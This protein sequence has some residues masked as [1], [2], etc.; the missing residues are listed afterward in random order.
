MTTTKSHYEVLEIPPTAPAGDIKRAFRQQIALYHPDKVQHLGKEFQEIAAGRAAALTEA[1]RV[2][3]DDAQRAA[4]DRSLAASGAPP[5]PP[6]PAPPSTPAA[7]PA[8]GPAV[9]EPAP[10]PSRG[11][12]TSE[13]ATRDQFVRKATVERIRRAAAP[14]GADY[15]ETEVR[16]FDIALAPRPRLFGG[17]NR[18]R[19][20][21]RF[22]EPVDRSAVTDAWA[23]AVRANAAA[24]DGVCV[25][26]FGS[27]VAPA[28]ELA[29][30]IADQR[31]KNRS[32]KVTL[33]PVDVRTWEAHIP[34]DA[35]GVCREL[36][37]RLKSG[38]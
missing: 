16:G 6:A 15:S 37:T 33:I 17:G 13:R 1:Y 8:A 36:L 29:S 4:Y 34:V 9:E 19:L 5:P 35:P 26:L 10:G 14:L 22:I 27:L 21:G 23:L 24:K 20:L 31:R 12:F 25:M 32:A 2:L 18:P 7:A 3:S 30:A 28:G 11:M 38:A